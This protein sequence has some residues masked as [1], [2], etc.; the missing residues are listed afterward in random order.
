MGVRR[1]VL[2]LLLSGCLLLLLEEL[3][4]LLGSSLCHLVSCGGVVVHVLPLPLL[5]L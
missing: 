2:K 3:L 4:G 5:E 1:A